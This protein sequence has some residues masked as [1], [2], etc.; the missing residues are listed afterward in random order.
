MLVA[1]IV[2]AVAVLL[3]GIGI[4]FLLKINQ[5]HAETNSRTQAYA[6]GLTETLQNR[7][8]VISE[9]DVERAELRKQLEKQKAELDVAHEFLERLVVVAPEDASLLKK[10]SEDEVAPE[11]E[12][13]E[14]VS[15]STEKDN[16]E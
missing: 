8:V 6:Q 11:D 12:K 5:A 4:L 15:T 10:K 16:P 1:V 9:M 13:E 2:L 14:V 3:L 7:E